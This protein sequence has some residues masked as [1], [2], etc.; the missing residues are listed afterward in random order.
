MTATGV[1]VVPDGTLVDR[2]LEHLTERSADSLTLA[3]DVL[4]IAKAT[5][6][7]AERVAEALLGADP[8]VRRL[9]DG[10]SGFTSDAN[11]GSI[12]PPLRP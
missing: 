8:R 7:I 3:R 12:T 10:R 1:R 9:T 2:V 5:P 11:T 4:G 6:A